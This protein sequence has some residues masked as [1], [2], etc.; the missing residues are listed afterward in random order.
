MTPSFP[1]AHNI[2]GIIKRGNKKAK[3]SN[4]YQDFGAGTAYPSSNHPS[5][6]Y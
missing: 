3:C 5:F 1:Y 6:F 2:L 4:F